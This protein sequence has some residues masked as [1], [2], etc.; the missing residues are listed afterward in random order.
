M[1]D[2]P[3]NIESGGHD[4]DSSDDSRQTRDYYGFGD[5]LH[6]PSCEETFSSVTFESDHGRFQEVDCDEIE[7]PTEEAELI[8]AW[9]FGDSE[10]RYVLTHLIAQGGGGEVWEGQHLVLKRIIAAKRPHFSWHV[11]AKRTSEESE[12]EKSQRSTP[13]DSPKLRA[14]LREAMVGAVLEHPNILPVYDLGKDMDGSPLIIMRLMKGRPWS[15]ILDEDRD[16]LSSDDFLFRHLPILNQVANAVAYAHSRGIIHRDL[17]PSQVMLGDYGE[18]QLMDWG[19]ATVLDPQTLPEKWAVEDAPLRPGIDGV[20]NPA[21]TPAYMAP[22][23]TSTSAE[24][25]GPWTD[26]FLLGATL[27]FILT[28]KTPYGS[29]TT[30]QAINKAAE[31]AL[32]PLK[33]ALPNQN[34]PAELEAL[35]MESMT[36]DWRERQLTALQFRRR[37]EEFLTGY[38]QKAESRTITD[39]VEKIIENGIE[40]YRE[41]TAAL[42]SL[43][44]ARGLWGANPKL[45]I[46]R[47]DILERYVSHA[48]ERGDLNLAQVQA[49]RLPDGPIK[50][51]LLAAIIREEK[52]IKRRETQ[53]R[54]A[55]AFAGA[56]MVAVVGASIFAVNQWHRAEE[57][58]GRSIAAER[59]ARSSQ[60][61]AL[62][63]M[64]TAETEAYFSGIGFA[65]SSIREGNPEKAIETLIEGIP[66]HIRGW[67]W[68]ALMAKLNAD[69]VTLVKNAV[70]NRRVPFHSAFSPDGRLMA[71]SQQL[72]WVTIWDF[73]RLEILHERQYESRGVWSVEFH[74]EGD[75]L[76]LAGLDGVGYVV[77]VE[78]GE[79]Q[80]RFEGVRQE[81]QPIFRG[82]AWSPDGQRFATSGNTTNV[83]V[84]DGNDGTLIV[85][86]RID[87]GTYDIDW[88]PDG[89]HLLVGARTVTPVHL[90]DADTLETIH[91]IE[92][93]RT[94]ALTVTYSQTGSMFAV[95]TNSGF[96][97]VYNAEEATLL[98]EIRQRQTSVRSISF[99]HDDSLLALVTADGLVHLH[100]TKTGHQIQ[101]LIGAQQ[102]EKLRFHHKVNKLVGTAFDTI[103]LWNI[104]RINARRVDLAS[105]TAEE[106]SNAALLRLPSFPS[107]RLTVWSGYDESWVGQGVEHFYRASDKVVE[108]QLKDISFNHDRS[109]RAEVGFESR[110]LAI[111]KGNT[112]EVLHELV[113]DALGITS[114]FSPDGRY[115][116]TIDR[117]R[118][119]VIY[120]TEDFEPIPDLKIDSEGPIIPFSLAFSEDSTM[121]AVGY[122]HAELVVLDL[123][124]GD[125]LLRDTKSHPLGRPIAS[126]TFSR[127]GTLVATASSDEVSCVFEVS[128]G[129]L[130]STFTG[131]S[132]NVLAVDISPDNSRAISVG[133]DDHARVWVVET[134]REIFSLHI[135]PN[136]RTRLMGVRFTNDGTGVFI[137]NSLGRLQY[138]DTL[139]WSEFT[140]TMDCHD[141]EDIFR[142]LEEFKRSQRLSPEAAAA[143]IYW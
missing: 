142:C 92:T 8:R 76:L 69:D 137:A 60:D 124:T 123:E 63:A 20:I 5:Q 73:E 70:A 93:D 108:V 141:G 114:L 57:E 41:L 17:K 10:Y 62:R 23:Q 119:L 122:G 118:L 117:E 38:T 9:L 100:D 111:Y 139:S 50:E 34:I 126:I 129:R 85:D 130:V 88:S 105:L 55:F 135:S 35:V 98:H 127:D 133:M 28:G 51:Q 80:F 42:T 58:L 1:N 36:A 31:R 90:L 106:I 84:Y 81:S 2:R 89:R 128:S 61:Q 30:A 54:L 27:Y 101:V 29:T 66:S 115:L 12:G 138:Y 7:N 3:E 104:D 48:I 13:G 136:L 82:V 75:R 95:G 71:V 47:T 64:A 56:L 11:E 134:G 107:Q 52:R 110:N 46:L 59:Q 44:R 78:S 16:K 143:P 96:T 87:N 125:I 43:V 74:P 103:K 25:L 40:G 113:P 4:G 33:P 45:D 22:E 67:E 99:S 49:E 6:G 86:R 120:D 112:D 14:F 132:L 79:E 65:A 39:R 37:V 15:R 24:G 68:D 32:P 83:A 19:L 26:V 102:M 77:D 18:V 21:G 140:S 121:L 97:G 94:T 72:G 91:E 131:H 116:A 109:L 53:R